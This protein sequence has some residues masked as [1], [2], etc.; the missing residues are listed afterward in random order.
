MT[1]KENIMRFNN[2]LVNRLATL[3]FAVFVITA[4][5]LAQIIGGGSSL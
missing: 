1:K 4:G 2:V 5:P 3:V